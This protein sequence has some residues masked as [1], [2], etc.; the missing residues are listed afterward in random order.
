MKYDVITMGSATIDMFMYTKGELIKIET[1]SFKETL[2]AYP[3]GSKLV[4][5]KS[6]ISTGGGG[7]NTAVTFSRMGLK[8]GYI[9]KVGSDFYAEKILSE[10]K[11]E[12]IDFL[13]SKGKGNSGFSVILDSFASDRTI[14]TQKGEN[15]NLTLKEINL[16]QIDTHWLYLSSMLGSSFKTSVAVAKAVKLKNGKIAYNPS[17]YLTVKGINYL[18]P[19]LRYVDY[20]I[21]NKEEAQS[22]LKSNEDDIYFLLEHLKNYGFVSVIITDGA[23]GAFGID[24]FSK[25]YHLKPKKTKVVEST[26]A[27]DAFASGFMSGIIRGFE[28]QAAMEV[29]MLNAESVITHIGAKNNILTYKEVIK[30]MKLK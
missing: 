19:L 30:K 18:K 21:F 27:G 5:K 22:L 15:D 6:E 1:P 29:G 12:N 7:T 17:I 28:F 25:H 20:L 11:K 24:A 23:N 9:G 16:K 14:F 2:L 10:L 8:T 26:G 4:I 13:G 3:L